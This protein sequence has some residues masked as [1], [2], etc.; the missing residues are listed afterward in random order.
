VSTKAN[1]SR[2]QRV[3]E[4]KLNSAG[5]EPPYLR[6]RVLIT[7]RMRRMKRL[8]PT[9]PVGTDWTTVHIPL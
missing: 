2:F 8:P 4:R 5:Q 6:M 1:H 9:E 3:Q 7:G